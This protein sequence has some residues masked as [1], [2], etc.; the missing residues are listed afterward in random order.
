MNSK[1]IRDLTEAYLSVYDLEEGRFNEKGEFIRDGA[2]D[3]PEESESKPPR[4]PAGKQKKVKRAPMKTEESYDL[5]DL[6]LDHLLDEGYANTVENAEV[7]MANMSEG[8]LEEILGVLTEAEGS[9]GQTPKAAERY[10]TMRRKS[11]PTYLRHTP[12]GPVYT[13]T[14]DKEKNRDKF[15][16]KRLMA[17]DDPDAGSRAERR[18]TLPSSEFPGFEKDPQH[19]A[20]KF[21]ALRRARKISGK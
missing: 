16:T 1:E 5:Y 17:M 15:A 9:F 20:K 13:T 19:S 3:E 11:Q 14:T 4:P 18:S 8:W 7:I 2:E 10:R 6:V 21:R 12:V